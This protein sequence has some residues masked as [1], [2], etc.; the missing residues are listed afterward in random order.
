[1]FVC[2]IYYSF[3][4]VLIVVIVVFVVLLL[5]CFEF[6]YCRVLSF[7]I[8]QCVVIELCRLFPHNE[9]YNLRVCFN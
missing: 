4:L 9:L 5:S 6:C 1:M 7:F 3:S 2:I 8:Y